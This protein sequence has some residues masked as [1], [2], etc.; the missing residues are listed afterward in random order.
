MIRLLKRLNNQ[1]V[2]LSLLLLCVALVSLVPSDRAHAN[3]TTVLRVGLIPEQDLF[4]QKKRYQPLFDYLEQKLNIQVEVQILSRYG[5]L[6]DNFT[7]LELD[8]AFFGSFT[9]ALAIKNLGM[10][11][12]ARPHHIE[13]LSSYYGLIFVRKQ[14]GIRSAE[15]MY[16]KRMVFVDRATTAGY[17]LPLDYFKQNGITDY[18]T[19]FA[20][21]YF[22]GTHEDAILEVLKGHADVGAAKNTIFYQLARDNPQILDSL[23]ILATS[24][25][26]PENT[27]GVRSD[28][29][30]G[31]ATLLREHLLSMHQT[32]EGRMVLDLLGAQRFL[33]TT[34]EDY[35]PV[36][37]YTEHLG[38]DLSSYQYIN[39]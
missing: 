4:V 23:E 8:A 13:G 20:E 6:I 26:V 9:G 16:G 22:A 1:L 2:T 25:H 35:Q 7:E 24:P 18:S 3:A 39:E 17:L 31:L 37:D 15:D 12:L 14:S 28:L 34:A 27:F 29:P 30:S 36:F 11:P 21:Y 38:M 33:I 5:N 32:A 19:W 10:I